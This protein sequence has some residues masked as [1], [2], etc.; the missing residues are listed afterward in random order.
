MARSLIRLEGG[1]TR[2]AG[3]GEGR[4]RGVLASCGTVTRTF[5]VLIW[6]R[7]VWF[8]SAK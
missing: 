7:I 8:A 1:A 3:L 2:Y 6:R 5:W 4:G